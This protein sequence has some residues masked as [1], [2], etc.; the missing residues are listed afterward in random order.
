M[1]KVFTLITPVDN[2]TE[3][4]LDEPT[5]SE[6]KKLSADTTKHGAVE[7]TVLLICAQS[8]QPATIVNR[9]RA[10]DFKIIEKWYGGFFDD[11]QETSTT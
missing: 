6:I 4:E 3:L 7:A 8:K 11:P 9:L 5:I 2:V 10:R 1:S